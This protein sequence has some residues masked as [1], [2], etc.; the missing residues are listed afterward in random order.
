MRGSAGWGW[1]RLTVRRSPCADL[2]AFGPPFLFFVLSILLL[3]L[4]PLTRAGRDFESVPLTILLSPIDRESIGDF[5]PEASAVG[6]ALGSE[7]ALKQ[8]DILSN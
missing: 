2:S 4:C 6:W 5:V 3:L 1:L 8:Q 7:D